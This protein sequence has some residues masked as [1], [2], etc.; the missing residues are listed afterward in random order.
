MYYCLECNKKLCKD[1]YHEKH[2]NHKC[3][4]TEP[5]SFICEH[6]KDQRT[7]L[8]DITDEHLNILLVFL[9]AMIRFLVGET[10]TGYNMFQD[11]LDAL[12]FDEVA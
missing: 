10:V 5:V 7:D 11:F 6:N 8:D 9:E 12:Q 1:C 2:A 3:C 4:I